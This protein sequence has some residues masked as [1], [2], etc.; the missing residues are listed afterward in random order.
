LPEE[1]A[2]LPIR[3]WKWNPRRLDE[4]T[5]VLIGALALI[6]GAGAV[7][8]NFQQARQA[9]LLARQYQTAL[10]NLRQVQL[11]L[12]EAQSAQRGYLATG[13]EEFLET[14]YTGM[15]RVEFHLGKL[16]EIGKAI[17]PSR[18]PVGR[19]ATTGESPVR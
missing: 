10:R 5:Y 8:L 18:E 19:V 6:L 9:D 2:T 16:R 15:A 13:V 3:K 14:Y 12:M 7:Y 4:V 1:D 11:T 17:P